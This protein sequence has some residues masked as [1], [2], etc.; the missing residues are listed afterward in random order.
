MNWKKII[1][2]EIIYFFSIVILTLA[3]YSFVEARNYYLTSKSKELNLVQISNEKKIDSLNKLILPKDRKGQLIFNLTKL[4]EQ[5]ASD[6]DGMKY[7]KD[8][9][10]MFG[11]KKIFKQIDHISKQ[12]VRIK[13]ELTEIRNSYVP[14]DMNGFTFKCAFLFLILIYPIRFSFISIRWSIR[15]IKKNGL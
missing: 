10:V 14:N 15:T 3:I 5:G 12:Q 1:A 4:F 13:N 8:F 11:D 7:S 6:K 9:K 2:K